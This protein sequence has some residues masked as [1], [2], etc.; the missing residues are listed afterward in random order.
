[1]DLTTITEAL[2][3]HLGEDSGLDAV[4][5]FDCG[6]DGVVVLDGVSLP[7]RVV[8]DDIEADCTVAISLTDLVALM[9]GK[10]NPMTGYMTGRLRVS[11]NLKVAMK[12]QKVLGGA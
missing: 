8:N 4:L 6:A 10:L 12:L 1:M 9:K 2:R 5:K 7:N 11:G 3:S